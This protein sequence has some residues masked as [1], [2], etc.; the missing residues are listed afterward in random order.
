MPPPDAKR[1][2]GLLAK[3]LGVIALVIALVTA[4]VWS[5]IDFFAFN[6]FSTLLDEYHVP[7]KTEVTEMFLDA[8]HRGLTAAGLVSL[9]LGLGAGYVL[10]RMIL[11]P[12][13]QMIA[14]TRRIAK[15]DYTS[16]VMAESADEIGELGKAFNAMTDN[17][18]QT[19]KLRRQM[20]IDVAHELRAPLT[21]IRGYLEALSS[22]LLPS[23]PKTIALLHEE[24]LRLGNLTD[25]LMRLSAADAARLTL[26][27]EPM[28]L[29]VLITHSLSLFRSRF[30]EKSIAVEAQFRTG[31]PKI[32]ADAE[33]LAQV[34]QNIL[35]NASR[36]TPEG[37]T[38]RIS[39]E[40]TPR[41]VRTTC[42]NTG[43][44][45]TG[46]DISLIFERF[47]RVDKSRSR[48]HGGAG[49]GLA[50]AKEMVAAHGGTV[51]VESGG[52]ENRIWFDLP[53]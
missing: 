41:T 25:D 6:Y 10:I 21:N 37:G 46:Q 48:E 51:G 49:I 44:P 15:S 45:I 28:D 32:A 11:R 39:I 47:Y 9:A 50:I 34:V 19:E 29:G 16:D 8:A 3:L 36:Y 13:Y 27:K 20:V 4:I 43:E 14:V 40:R 2:S 30:A 12:L 1:R 5:S 52:G 38:V 53:A 18:Q 17:L 22:G 26:R 23:T 7:Q 31:G 42:A 24:T 35:D 33:K